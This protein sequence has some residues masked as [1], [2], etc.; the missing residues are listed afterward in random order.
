MII[1]L[2]VYMAI[3]VLLLLYLTIFYGD[4]LVDVAQGISD[5]DGTNIYIVYLVIDILI[6]FGGIPLVIHTLVTDRKDKEL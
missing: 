1:F 5:R 3:G 2:L 4:S 6:V